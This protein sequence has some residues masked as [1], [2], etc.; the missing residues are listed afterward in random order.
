MTQVTVVKLADLSAKEREALLQ[1]SAADLSGFF[2]TVRPIIAAVRSEGDAALARYGATLDG[3]VGLRAEALRASEDEF[4]AAFAMLDPDLTETIRYAIANIR[5]F[6]EEQRP[7]PM[8]LK[9]I[10]PGAFAGDRFTPLRSAAL[11]VPRGKGSFPSVTMMTSVPAVL[12]GVKDLAIFTPPTPEGGVDAATLVAARLAGVE[13]VYKVGGAQAVAA[14]AYGTQTI[15]RAVKIMGPGSP[16]VVAAK[17]LLADVIDPGLPAGP[18]ECIIF[19]DGTVHGGLAALDLLIEAEHGPDSCAWL[20]TTSEEVV[21]QAL[22]ALPDH[23]AQM[24]VQRRGFSQT[25]LTGRFGGIILA[26][27]LAEAYGFIN[28]YAPE[29]LEILSTRPFEHVG[30]LTEAAEILLGPHTPVSV[31]NF[32]LGPNNVL[33]TSAGARSHGPLSVMDFMKR[34]SI[35]YVTA[36]GW[37]E[38]A[39]HAHRLATYEGFDGHA[40]AVGPMRTRYLPQGD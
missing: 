33:P 32:C 16:Y 28:D 31:A 6:H 37:P 17:R 38:M 36:K 26:P 39:S 18:S 19:D 1:R 21:V 20:V 5:S 9:E 35:G 12:A 11:Y 24:S 15:G 40:N 14:A 29:H 22:A 3:A 27:S 8:S 34:S 4:D 25:V 30:A 23:W 13:T 10:R 7:D 2:D